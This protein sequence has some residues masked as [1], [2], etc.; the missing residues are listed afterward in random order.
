[1]TLII[2]LLIIGFV[3]VA[4]EVLVPGGILGIFAFIVFVA[5]TIVASNAY[6]GSAGLLVFCGSILGS[7]ATFLGMFKYVAI[8]K[9][10]GGLRL[11]AAIEGNASGQTLDPSL[12]GQSGVTTTKL[13]PNGLVSV[14]DQDFQ[15][16]SEDG[17]IESGESVTIHGIRHGDVL[18][19]KSI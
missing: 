13:V 10:G 7:V 14:G 5:A 18:V 19:R 15:A 12:I 11:D 6:G 8:S 3:L 16:H 17:Y 1:M 4:A 2:T 9:N